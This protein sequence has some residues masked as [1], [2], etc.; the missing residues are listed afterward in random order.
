MSAVQDARLDAIAAV[1]LMLD[2]DPD[3]A[4]KIIATTADPYQLAEAATAFTMSILLLVGPEARA[5]ILDRMTQ[6]A[7]TQEEA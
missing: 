5:L 1:R 2:G 4:R 3:D 6:A 7:A